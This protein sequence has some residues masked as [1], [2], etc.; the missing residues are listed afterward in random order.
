[1]KSLL[2]QVTPPAV[3]HGWLTTYR[4]VAYWRRWYGSG[5]GQ[6]SMRFIRSFKNQYQGQRCFI[7]GNGPSLRQTDLS[8]L[9]H[10]HTFGLNRIYLLFEEL[11]FTTSF[12]VSVNPNIAEQ[13]PDDINALPI[14]KFIG[15]RGRPF[16]QQDDHTAF[17]YSWAYPCFSTD[18][19]RY[20]WEGYTVTYVAMQLAYYMGFQQVILIGVDHNFIT[21]G[22]SNK[23]VVSAGDDPNH[24]APNYFGK[25][26]RWQ[27]PDLPNSEEAYK[28]A[29]DAFRKD[30]REILDAT[31]GGKLQVFPKVPYESLFSADHG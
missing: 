10:E 26:V 31:I 25:G 21:Q 28:L 30:G 4:L 1:M 23:L 19:S 22:P 24:F 13:W 3:W 29:R 8:L 2:K 16:L 20:I 11:G 14:P 15:L 9:R 7:I 5:Y 27:L 17:L 12:Y 18:P 6:A